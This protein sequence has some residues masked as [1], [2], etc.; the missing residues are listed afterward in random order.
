MAD[1]LENLEA[2]I[3]NILQDEGPMTLADLINLISQPHTYD[4]C[5]LLAA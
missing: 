3:D 1:K 4:T 5:R 2:L